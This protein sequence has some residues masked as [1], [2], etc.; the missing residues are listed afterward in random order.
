MRRIISF[1]ALNTFLLVAVWCSAWSQ[2]LKPLKNEDVIE[3]F[4]AG[5]GES[6]I[7]LRI[8]NGITTF[9]LGVDDLIGLKTAGV[10]D[11]IIEAM[12]R[13]SGPAPVSVPDRR[14]IETSERM[15]I[16]PVKI[17]GTIAADDDAKG[18]TFKFTYPKPNY[19]EPTY[20]SLMDRF[21]QLMA[22][23]LSNENESLYKLF[24]IIRGKKS[25]KR[26]FTYKKIEYTGDT[27]TTSETIGGATDEVTWDNKVTTKI[28]RLNI[29]GDQILFTEIG[30][31]KG[32]AA[33]HKAAV[34][35]IEV[36]APQNR[37]VN[38]AFH[39]HGVLRGWCLGLLVINSRELTF[40]A[41]YFGNNRGDRHFFQFEIGSIAE[42]QRDKRKL[43]VRLND[44][45]KFPFETTEERVDEIADLLLRLKP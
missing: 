29:Q 12:I 9:K 2:E 3:M 22:P 23:E 16:L 24:A 33:D 18:E 32:E 45:R 37:F 13:A 8:G 4:K 1:A 39:N 26:V 44:G 7:V 42:V 20:T 28:Y 27:F 5:I 38:E 6:V 25:G 17:V 41:T 36:S 35:D 21:R 15:S 34:R 43:T 11:T 14:S 40:N 10:T 31:T 30:K 19:S